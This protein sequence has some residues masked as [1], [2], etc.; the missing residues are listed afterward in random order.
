[1]K[2]LFTYGFLI[3]FFV[4][5]FSVCNARNLGQQSSSPSKAYSV[6]F[7][8]FYPDKNNPEHSR[9]PGAFSWDEYRSFL[10][11]WQELPILLYTFC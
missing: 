9:V 1:M 3:I 11:S 10:K 4:S 7:L 6:R 5:S 2:K 8:P